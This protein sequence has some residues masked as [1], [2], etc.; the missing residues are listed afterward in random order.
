MDTKRN[1]IGL[2]S[3]VGTLHGK[4]K[5]SKLRTDSE[6]IKKELQ[7]SGKSPNLINNSSIDE[8]ID[9][10]KEQVELAI[11][12]V[13]VDSIDSLSVGQTKIS[14]NKAVILSWSVDQSAAPPSTPPTAPPAAQADTESEDG[15][16]LYVAI[17]IKKA[18][19]DT[20]EDKPQPRDDENNNSK[21]DKTDHMVEGSEQE[22]TV[23]DESGAEASP[24]IQTERNATIRNLKI[25]LCVM[26]C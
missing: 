4:Q 7:N 17:K 23:V 15:I 24:A 3:S 9:A 25:Y 16:V 8:N 22:S 21:N 6:N 18:N 14:K 5:P 26:I 20:N 1:I 10:L 13:G 2:A 11:R 12:N 19:K